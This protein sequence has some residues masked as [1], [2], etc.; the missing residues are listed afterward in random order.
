MSPSRIAPV[1]I[2]LLSVSALGVTATSLEA[3]LTTDPKEEIDPEWDQLMLDV[4]I[5]AVLAY[6]LASFLHVLAAPEAADAR[7]VGAHEHADRVAGG[8]G[9]CGALQVDQPL[10]HL[11]AGSG[12]H[13]VVVLR[14]HQRVAVDEDDIPTR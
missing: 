4:N 7:P 9:R 5:G 10:H 1:L 8:I 11:P 12:G 6:L 2:A 3:T 13:V 14:E